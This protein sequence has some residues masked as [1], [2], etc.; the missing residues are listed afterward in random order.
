MS[1]AVSLHVISGSTPCN[2]RAAEKEEAAEEGK[3]KKGG[4]QIPEEWPWEAAK[5][6]FMKPDVTA[7]DK[8]DLEWKNPDIEG[9]V[10]F[11]VRDKG[12]KYAFTA[13]VEHGCVGR[14]TRCPSEERVR[15]GGEKL[16]KFLNAKQQGRLD[17]FFSVKPKA[18]P[19]KKDKAEGKGAKGKGTKRKVSLHFRLPR[20][21]C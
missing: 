5:E 9:L 13:F 20:L 1:V 15:K 8:L 17:G 11:L 4:I 19:T 21:A 6:L 3:K 16:S 2:R 10:D 14:L 18:S 12:F 7:A